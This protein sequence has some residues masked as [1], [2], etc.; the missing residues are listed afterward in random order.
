MDFT[1]RNNT[2]L[3]ILLGPRDNFQFN[4]CS[5]FEENF[6]DPYVFFNLKDHCVC[7]S[8]ECP[9]NLRAFISEPLL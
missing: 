8:L 9:V 1:L 2:F 6:L 7:L 5:F 4:F 3:T